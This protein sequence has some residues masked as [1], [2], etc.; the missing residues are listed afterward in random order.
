MTA[1]SDALSDLNP[2]QVIIMLLFLAA[3]I[4]VLAAA[5]PFDD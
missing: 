5:L 4:L 3:A 1:F 2:D